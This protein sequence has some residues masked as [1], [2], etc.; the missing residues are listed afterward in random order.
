MDENLKTLLRIWSAFIYEGKLDHLS[1]PRRCRAL[2]D[3]IDDLVEGK[4]S[5]DQLISAYSP[6]EEDGIK[7]DQ[8]S[9]GNSD[10]V[11]TSPPTTGG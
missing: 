10:K 9:V 8:Q 5:V 4:M 1:A 6:A 2:S 7:H 3:D 11:K